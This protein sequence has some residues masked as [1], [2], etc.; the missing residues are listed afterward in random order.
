MHSA[1]IYSVEPSLAKL[2]V[3]K[4]ET[5]GSGIS[6]GSNDLGETVTTKP[7]DGRTP[8]IRNLEKPGHVIDT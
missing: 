8:L 5:G 3:L 1:K 2:D 7:V 4:S 6:R